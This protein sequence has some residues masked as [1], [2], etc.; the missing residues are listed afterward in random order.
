M[1]RN[2]SVSCIRRAL[3]SDSGSP[4]E[5]ITSSIESSP[6]ISS[7]R[8]LPARAVVGCGLIRELA[9]EAVAA[10]HRAGSGGD[11]QRPAVILVQQARRAHGGALA[12]RIAAEAGG[13]DQFARAR[14]HLP[15]QR[16]RRVAARACGARSRAAPAGGNR[17]RPA[18]A[19]PAAS[20][21]SRSQH[22]A[23]VRADR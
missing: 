22:A 6:A 11:Q 5:R 19:A 8:R 15:Q 9:P 23:A 13:F 3:L 7:E 21:G 20:C 18:H 2:A 14:Q 16:V 4:P 10:V 1:A 17:S 12:Q